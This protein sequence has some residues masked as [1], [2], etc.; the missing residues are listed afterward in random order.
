MTLSELIDRLSAHPDQDAVFK[1]GFKN[2][3]SWRGSY[4]E[5]AFEPAK[6]VPL[7][8]M[9][10][11]AE[12]ALGAT[13]TG[14]KGGEFTMNKHTSVNIDTYGNWTDHKAMWDMMLELMFNQK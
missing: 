5:L 8:L 1:I 2:P 3:N 4:D 6:D 11:Q 12:D 14:Y 9:L 7:K 13:F 10:K